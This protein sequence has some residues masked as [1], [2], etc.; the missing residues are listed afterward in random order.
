MKKIPPL[1]S[2]QEEIMNIVWE[3]G[4]VTVNDV[5]EAISQRRATT[6][7]TIQ[8]LLVRMKNKGWVQT[9][10]VGQ[11]FVYR[12]VKPR[13]VSLSQKAQSLLNR[14]FEGSA[15]KLMNALLE[16]YELS[17]DD[18]ERLRELID[19]AE[20]DNAKSGFKKKKKSRKQQ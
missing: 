2:A 16:D 7:T 8:T 6:R 5:V 17:N 19:R 4:E 14:Y 9:R 15:P 10:Q 1:S 20:N 3:T 11:A 18:A 12:A 13:K